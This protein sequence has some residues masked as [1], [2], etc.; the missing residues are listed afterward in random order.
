MSVHAAGGAGNRLDFE[1]GD[2][3]VHDFKICFKV[4][5][6]YL[7]EEH[8]KFGLDL[9]SLV[10]EIELVSLLLTQDAIDELLELLW[11]C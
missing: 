3:M 9:L 1:V 4:A 7:L 5:V 10:E 11:A 2:R 6:A 8:L